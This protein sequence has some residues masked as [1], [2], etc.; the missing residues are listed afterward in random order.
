MIFLLMAK[1]TWLGVQLC[2]TS[3]AGLARKAS[4]L[5]YALGMWR[6]A[7][8]ARARSSLASQSAIISTKPS[9]LAA[10]PCAGPMK[11]VPMMPALIV[12]MNAAS[13]PHTLSRAPGE[14]TRLGVDF[15]LFPFFDEE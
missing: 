3:M 4:T 8:F 13:N 2:T 5:P 12:F 7:A 10:S 1:C 6:D 11:P 9:R 15:H 14:L